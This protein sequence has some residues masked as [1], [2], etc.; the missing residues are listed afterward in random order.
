MK[1]EDDF[2]YDDALTAWVM[3]DCRYASCF[4]TTAAV[5]C[6][7]SRLIKLFCGQKTRFECLDFESLCYEQPA[8]GQARTLTEGLS[9][10]MMFDGSG[11]SGT[12]STASTGVHQC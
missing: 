10:T 4:S 3:P 9:A 5:Q 12:R 2:F 1:I 8:L 11:W 7:N 6:S